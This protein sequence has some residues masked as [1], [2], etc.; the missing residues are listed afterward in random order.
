MF[1]VID[2]VKKLI[3]ESCSMKI[4][5]LRKNIPIKILITVIKSDSSSIKKNKKIEGAPI[6]LNN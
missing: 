2:I 6:I 4:E 3:K 1:G 5:K